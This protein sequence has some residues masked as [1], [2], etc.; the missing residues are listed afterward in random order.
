MIDQVL[1]L[2]VIR[3]DVSDC[4]MKIVMALIWKGPDIWLI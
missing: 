3:C 2:L 1:L 4:T